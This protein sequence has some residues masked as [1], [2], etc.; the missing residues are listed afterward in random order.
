MVV[1]QR[2]TLRRGLG[3]NR[4]GG[5]IVSSTVLS[6]GVAGTFGVIQR[7]YANPDFSGEPLY[8]R[9][10]VK[11][12]SVVYQVATFNAPLGAWHSGQL[13]VNAIPS[14]SDFEISEI[15]CMSS[16]EPPQSKKFLPII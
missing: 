16:S 1:I 13:L 2:K 12:A 14:G 5:Y 11:V 7:Y 6:L 3:L 15:N 4:I 8:Q 10:Y 9:A